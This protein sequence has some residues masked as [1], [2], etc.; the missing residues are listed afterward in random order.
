[1]MSADNS[2]SIDE[3]LSRQAAGEALT[4][5]DA[6]RLVE[7][8]LDDAITIERFGEWLTTTASRAPTA[9]EIAGVADALRTR[10]RPIRAVHPVIGDTCGTGGDGSGSFNISTAAA[11]VVAAAGLPVAKH[12]NRAVSSRTGSADVLERLGVEVAQP[13][14]VAERCLADVGIAF[15]FAPAHHPALAKLR[16]L[17]RSIGRPTV[18]NLV[19][20]LCNPAGAT[21]QVIGVGRDDARWPVAEAA[22]L[23]G[24]QRAIV[25]RS[26]DGVDEVGLFTPTRVLDVSPAG[27]REATWCPEDF[28]V[29]TRSTADRSPLLA[30]D[31]EES[32]GCI[33]AV[34]NG[35]LG[36][37]RD[38][39]VLNAAALLWAAGRAD[40]LAE[41]MPLATAAIDSGQARNVL[42]R[43]QVASHASET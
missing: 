30:A 17:R 42:E 18:F 35:E 32:A 11:L 10:M 21:V 13:P 24:M 31:A 15:L 8:V 25:V 12:G 28:G 4:R 19:G 27:I 2:A 6:R 34:L 1:M 5:G 26:D 33:R 14:A 20:P 29:A 36:P 22:Q 9:A 38:I 39:V 37:C 23:L 16:D 7:A 40:D 3:V 41:A 43:L